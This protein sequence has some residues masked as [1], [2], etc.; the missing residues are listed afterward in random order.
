MSQSPCQIPRGRLECQVL[1]IDEH[2]RIRYTRSHVQRTEKN[3]IVN[4]ESSGFLCPIT[5]ATRSIALKYRRPCVCE[6][7]T[8]VEGYETSR[9]NGSI[10]PKVDLSASTLLEGQG[11]DTLQMFLDIELQPLTRDKRQKH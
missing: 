10:L 8:L 9:S 3:T 5:D 4:A 7:I 2:V 11:N 6:Q 1:L